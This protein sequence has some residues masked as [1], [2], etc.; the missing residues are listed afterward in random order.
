M[1][2]CGLPENA[3]SM[4]GLGV[5]AL[6]YARARVSLLGTQEHMGIVNRALDA[7]DGLR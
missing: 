5:G 6:A 4:E 2:D 3:G 7:L 1:S